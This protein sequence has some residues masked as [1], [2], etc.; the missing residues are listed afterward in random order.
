MQKGKSLFKSSD[1][2]D[3]AFTEKR[4]KALQ[5]FLKR[6]VAHPELINDPLLHQVRKEKRKRERGKEGKRKKTKTKKKQNRFV[7]AQPC[8]HSHYVHLAVS[9]IC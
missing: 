2:A 7:H 3:D 8:A 6:V 4:A 9:H 1:G 5:R